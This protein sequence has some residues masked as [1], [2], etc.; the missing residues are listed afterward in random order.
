M[1]KTVN[2]IKQEVI[3]Q[4]EEK[5]NYSIQQAKIEQLERQ[6]KALSD[7]NDSLSHQVTGKTKEIETQTE[8]I[9]F[10]DEKVKNLTRENASLIGQIEAYEKVLRL[11]FVD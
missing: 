9:R 6:N 10:L 7:L 4:A 2:E 5:M 8:T 11:R 1:G 3:E